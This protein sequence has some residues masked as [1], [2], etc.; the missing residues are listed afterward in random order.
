MQIYQWEP[1]TEEFYDKLQ[2]FNESAAKSSIFGYA[3]DASSVSTQLASVTN[4]VAEYRP[5][6][7]TGSVEDVDAA[8][9]EFNEKL[10]GA[11][12][13]DIFDANQSQLDEWLAANQ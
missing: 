6:L 5:S 4:V 10:E 3:F 8:I 11:G 7:L 12:I 9:G 1:E 13:Q 2:E